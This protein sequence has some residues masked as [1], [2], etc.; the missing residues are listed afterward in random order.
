MS[1]TIV[2]APRSAID[3]TSS[4]R[5]YRG[6]RIVVTGGRPRWR[7][8]AGIDQTVEEMLCASS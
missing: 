2:A 6:K 5:F 4:P 3:A 7:L 1:A 8:A